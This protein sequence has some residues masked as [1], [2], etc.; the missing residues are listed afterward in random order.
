[1]L[2]FLMCIRMKYSKLTKF[3]RI[4]STSQLYQGE[5]GIISHMIMQGQ[6]IQNRYHN[7]Y[8]PKI[9]SS[10]QS[11]MHDRH[12]PQL[13]SFENVCLSKGHGLLVCWCHWWHAAVSKERYNKGFFNKT[14]AS[15][16]F[17][18]APQHSVLYS[19]ILPAPLSDILIFNRFD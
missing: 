17:V 13:K 19:R 7:N 4:S 11:V 18:C 12:C 15:D 14:P 5:N 8:S 9:S 10:K 6:K 2:E 16:D 1:M 3:R